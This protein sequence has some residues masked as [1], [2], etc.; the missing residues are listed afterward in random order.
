[1]REYIKTAFLLLAVL[2]VSVVLFYCIS[3]ADIPDWLKLALL[4]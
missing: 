1:M 4:W 2:A 3:T